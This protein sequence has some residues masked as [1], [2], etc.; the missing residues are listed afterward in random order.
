MSSMHGL[1]KLPA[2]KARTANSRLTL[3]L[4]H[5][6]DA[7]TVISRPQV[8]PGEHYGEDAAAAGGGER[9]PTGAVVGIIRRNWRTRGYAGSLQPPGAGRAP[10]RGTASVLFC[11]VER[12]FPFVRI[13]TRQARP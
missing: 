2:Q 8:A 4:M 13:Q 7:I 11:P 10:R 1:H 6:K 12:R 9:R 3:S 5:L